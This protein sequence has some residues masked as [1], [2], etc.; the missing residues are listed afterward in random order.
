MPHSLVN[1]ITHYTDMTAFCLT[2]TQQTELLNRSFN[3]KLIVLLPPVLE[4]IIT[5]YYPS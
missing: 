4:L 2:H 5:N 1:N 3:V